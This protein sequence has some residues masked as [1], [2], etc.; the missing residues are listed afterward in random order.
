M[1]IGGKDRPMCCLGCKAVATL[2]RDANL[3][4]FYSQRSAFPP[5]PH[6]ENQTVDLA[7]QQNLDDIR[8]ETDGDISQISLLV[9]GMNCAA[10]SWV[11]E[12]LLKQIPGVTDVKTSLSLSRVDVL[13][14]AD[15]STAA[16][17]AQLEALGYEVKPWRSDLTLTAAREEQRRDLRRIGVAGIGMMQ[18]GMLAIALHAGD[19][20]GMSAGLQQLLRSISAPLTLLVLFYSGRA[21]LIPAWRHLLQGKL[22]MDS[23]VSLALLVATVVSLWATYTGRGVTYYDTVTMFIFFLLSARF[24]ERRLRLRD[25]LNIARLEDCL[26]SRVSTLRQR[27]W[28]RLAQADVLPG[29]HIRVPQ[30]DIVPFDSEVIEGQS[31]V[32]EAVLNGESLPRAVTRGDTVYAGTI[33]NDSVLEARVIQPSESSR[34]AALGQSLQQAQQDKAPY[35]TLIDQLAGY[36]VAGIITL[37]AITFIFQSLYSDVD[38]AIW[39]T[40][41]VLVVACPCALSIATPAT[42]AS[43]SAGLSRLGILVNGESALLKLADADRALIDKTGTLTRTKLHVDNIVLAKGVDAERVLALSAALQDVSRHPAAE[44]FKG[45]D[46][47]LDVEGARFMPG[48]GVTGS[49]SNDGGTLRLGSEAYCRELCPTL[50][51]IPDDQQYWIV[52][53]QDNNWLAWIGLQEQLTPGAEEAVNQLQTAGLQP[54]LVSGDRGIRV[55]ALADKLG[56]PWQA[57][58]SPDDKRQLITALQQGNHQVLAMGDGLN[59]APFLAAANVSVAVAGASALTRAQ[60]D[61]VITTEELNR[62]PKLMI[63]AKRTRDIVRQNL[64]WALAYNVAT[65][66]AAALG[67]VPPWLAAVGMSLSSLLVLLNALRARGLGTIK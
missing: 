40:I 65:I 51:S 66:P 9:T 7:P 11:I 12:H 49:L 46:M 31:T 54:R 14:T 3:G 43:G 59:D 50:P 28:Q 60:A 26:P 53:V 61:F 63:L 4:N 5:K 29:D 19:L 35:V 45:F 22:I 18:V 67:Y 41:A 25:V 30:G 36:F 42:L 33:N 16:I 57:E 58:Q 15:A 32:D 27:Q 64:F 13:L 2:I 17:A 39:S 1:T 55:K 47:A 34:L 62:L 20:Q 10:C 24:L 23:S 44:S 38:T 52:L 21:F 37:A 56:I 8:V 48:R 6:T